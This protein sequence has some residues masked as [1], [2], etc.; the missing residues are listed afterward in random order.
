MRM[1]MVM[2]LGA[3]T[4]LPVS[5]CADDDAATAGSE[6]SAFL[7]RDGDVVTALPGLEAKSDYSTA[8]N[9]CVVG[10]VDL[11]G[12]T[13]RADAGVVRQ[14]SQ[15]SSQA[16]AGEAWSVV[17]SVFD[18]PSVAEA[19]SAAEAVLNLVGTDPVDVG[20]ALV[21]LTEPQDGR[22]SGVI[23]VTHDSLMATVEI[24]YVGRGDQ[25][26]AERL[27]EKAAQRLG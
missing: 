11:A 9:Y 21:A 5:G 22:S 13:E 26:L 18:F 1:A 3:L 17:S 8:K 24:G 4:L 16:K 6:L 7:L 14:W 10:E 12:P 15:D 2:L 20:E 19:E 25:Q 23:V 27:A